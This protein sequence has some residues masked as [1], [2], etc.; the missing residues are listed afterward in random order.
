MNLM[1]RRLFG[2]KPRNR[3]AYLTG[4]DP[5]AE[6]FTPQG[7]HRENNIL[8]PRPRPEDVP[9]DGSYPVLKPR[10]INAAQPVA[11]NS[12]TLKPRDLTD[13]PLSR[14]DAAMDT[15][16]PAPT[17][18]ERYLATAQPVQEQP[19]NN[20]PTLHERP[21]MV[22]GQPVSTPNPLSPTERASARIDQRDARIEELTTHPFARKTKWY[23]RAAFGAIEGLQQLNQTLMNTRDPRTGQSTLVRAKAAA[24]VG[25]GAAAATAMPKAVAGILNER[26]LTQLKGKRAEDFEKQ[27]TLLTRA[28]QEAETERIKAQT[29][30][31]RKRPELEASKQKSIEHERR[32][33]NVIALINKLPEFNPHEADNQDIVE[34]MRELGIPIVRR[35]AN[36][37]IVVK[38]DAANGRITVVAVDK[39]SGEPTATVAT[40]KD[41]QPIQMATPS[42]VAAET[43]DENRESRENEGDKNRGVRVSE[44]EKNR[45]ARTSGG[46]SAGARRT[47]EARIRTNKA[48]AQAA[49]RKSRNVDAD[50]YDE[51]VRGDEAMLNQA[52]G[53]A[54]DGGW[55]GQSGS[56]QPRHAGGRMSRSKLPEMARRRGIT[57]AEAEQQVKAEGIELY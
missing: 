31:T 28:K 33:K 29:D 36:Q 46:M 26:E 56:S 30:Y 25:G 13:Q 40:G 24:I 44:G 10:D 43:A 39:G 52:T 5:A 4:D 12:P 19:V 41:G 37:Q 45:A 2:E 51:L 38:Q 20:T 53:G 34:E 15:N 22:E 9:T 8:S 50:M 1:D 23:E 32:R 42:S 48:R 54:G 7:V 57:E 21:R 55:G 3:M 17:L 11:N 6:L 27:G 14:R 47:I 16:V 18:A 35:K 49:R